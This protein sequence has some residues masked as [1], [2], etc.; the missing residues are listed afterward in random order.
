MTQ[1][2]EGIVLQGDW[3]KS[4]QLL[5]SLGSHGLF[6]SYSLS[7]PAHSQW[8]RIHGTDADGDLPTAR[9]GHAMCMD[10]VNEIIYIFGGWD[11][12][13]SLDDFWAYYVKEDKWKLLSPSTTVEQ[14]APGARS[15]HKMVFDSKTGSI[16]VLGRLNDTDGLRAPTRQSTLATVLGGQSTPQP[17]TQTSSAGAAGGSSSELV[18][19]TTRNLSSEFYRYHT[20]GMLA[21]KWDFLSIDTAVWLLFSSR[22]KLANN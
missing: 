10:P 18:E 20:R 22:L 14:N 4:E 2:H 7:S 5:Q 15:C 6:E 9:G 21:G 8:T 19:E 1:L 3:S 17:N 11:G 12:K 16:Y 13:K